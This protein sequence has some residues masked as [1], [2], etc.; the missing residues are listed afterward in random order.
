MKRAKVQIILDCRGE[1]VIA[2]HLRLLENSVA[3]VLGSERLY[4]SF[5]V[6]R[7][8]LLHDFLGRESSPATKMHEER[9]HE[10]S[11]D[12]YMSDDEQESPYNRVPVGRL[13]NVAKPEGY[14]KC[15]NSQFPAIYET[16]TKP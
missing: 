1:A 8:D 16:G 10:P 13:I 5:Y 7:T 3:A 9:F 4:H 11:F 6:T 2:A 15:L 12:L 14:E